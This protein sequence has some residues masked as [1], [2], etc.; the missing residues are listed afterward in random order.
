MS[1]AAGVSR[2]EGPIRGAQSFVGVMTTVWRMPSLSVLEVAWRWAVG[3]PILALA[4]WQALGMWHRVKV[5]TVALQAM[6][7]FQPVAAFHTIG[8]AV[9]VI[10]PAAKP[11]AAWLFPLAAMMWVLVAAF[12]R[13]FVLRRFDRTLHAR[14]MTLLALGVLRGILLAMMWLLWFWLILQAGRT[15][16]TGPAAQGAEPNVVLYSA[17]LICESILLYVLWAVFSWPFQLAPLLAMQLNLG[18]RAALVASFRS[19]LARNKIIEINLVMNI[20]K[21]AVLVLGM[22]FSAC[23]LP[24]A[25]VESPGFLAC[26]WTGVMLVYLSALDYFHVVRSVAHLSLWRAFRS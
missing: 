26:W 8:A 25:N 3:T 15:A 24:F 22:V 14:P 17:I 7:V 10:L 21:I 20:V 5:D 16:I 4:V 2:A 1:S 11:L 13:T 18:P 12:G 9:A 6:S 19:K 23:P